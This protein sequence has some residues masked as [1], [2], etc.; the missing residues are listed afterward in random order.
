M[1]WGG[2][3][4]LRWMAEDMISSRRWYTT[5]Y[6]NS[7]IGNRMNLL[8]IGIPQSTTPTRF[9]HFLILRYTQPATTTRFSHSLDSGAPE[10]ATSITLS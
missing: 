8:T 6:H 3:S 5:A 10:P 7:P 1:S 2:W 4:R 9:S